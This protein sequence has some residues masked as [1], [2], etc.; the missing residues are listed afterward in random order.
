MNRKFAPLFITPVFFLYACGGGSSSG[1]GGSGGGGGTTPQAISVSFPSGI[2][3]ATLNGGAQTPLEANVA[4]DSAN[5]GVT[6]SCAPAGSC[7]SF[8]PSTTTSGNPTT[9]TAPIGASTPASVTVTATS[10]TDPTKNAH[11]TIAINA[12]A[13]Q[14]AQAPPAS[15]LIS[16]TTS[17]AA[18][19]LSDSANAGVTW[20]CTPANSCGSF[21]PT[22]TLSGNTT[23]YTAPPSVPT[24]ATVTI[25]ATSITDTTKT[26]QAS[27]TITSNITVALSQPYPATLLTSGTA[28]LAALVTNDI[29]GGGVTWSCTPST[30]CGAFNPTATPSGTPTT[31]SAPATP[32][33]GGT[34]TIIAASVTDPSKTASASIVITGTASVSMLKG[35]YAFLA[36]APTGLRGNT[37][38]VG[39]VTLDGTGKVAAGVEDI[40]SPTYN[41]QDDIILPT[42]TYTVDPS[43]HGRLTILTTNGETLGISFVATSPSHAEIIEADPMGGDGGDPA[44][45]SLDLQTPT[46]TGFA[47]SQ[48]S[49]DYSFVMSGIDISSTATPKPYLAFGGEF[50]AAGSSGINTGAIDVTSTAAAIQLS[51]ITSGAVDIAPDSNGRGSFHIVVSTP[52]VSRTFVFYIVS[53][54][55]LRLMESDG[56]AAMGGSAYLQGTASTALSGTYV[57]QHSG[58]SST[59]RTVAAGQFSLPSANTTISGGISDANAGAAAPTT[60]TAAVAVSGSYTVVTTENDT[61]T[62]SLTDAAGTSTLNAYFVDPSIN[63]LD[64]NN[65]SG[66]GGAL[67]LHTNANINGVGILV[68]Q[69]TPAPFAGGYALSL[70]NSIAATTRNELDLVGVLAADGK[71]SFGGSNLADYDQNDSTS[72]NPMI[73]AGLSGSFAADTTHSSTGRYTGSFT[74]TPPSTATSPYP[75]IPGSAFTV[76]IYPTG[77]SQAFIVETDKQSSIIGRILQQILP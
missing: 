26:A 2:P 49:G 48:M 56:I 28:L 17:V 10:V 67:L 21:S 30:S 44:S 36:Q 39:S 59:G 4:N 1:S 50:S 42:S 35:Q 27:V 34:V 57:Y 19:V 16:T 14:L 11:A 8:S 31:Y 51:V 66:G 72:P 61:V 5:A 20:S 76:A 64:P 65:S 18:T 15:L 6:W 3:P 43:G 46:S 73:G 40:V 62:F 37:T 7:G 53:S 29:S 74:V 71:S 23:T 52:G 38:W 33:T 25:I 24:G 22:T 75:F 13:V 55:V 68:P 32:P 54:K 47:A 9:Y 12:I 41:D 60:A 45:G 63:I 77:N 70:T 69:T 58:W